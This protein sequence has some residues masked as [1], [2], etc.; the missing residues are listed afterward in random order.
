MFRTSSHFPPVL[1]FGI[2]QYYFWIGDFEEG[3]YVVL[4]PIKSVSIPSRG[5]FI[6]IMF[7]SVEQP[8]S[9]EK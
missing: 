7:I 2:L 3:Y 5:I 1:D 4:Q 8:Y 6:I 9:L